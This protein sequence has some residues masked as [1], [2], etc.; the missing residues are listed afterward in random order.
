MHPCCA[1]QIL[2]L[3]HGR[4]PYDWL[5]KLQDKNAEKHAQRW[6]CYWNKD[7]GAILQK[8]ELDVK[9]RYDWHF[10]TTNWIRAC[11]QRPPS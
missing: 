1:G 4:S 3:E 8:A 7:I 10:G 2:L 5:A 9:A 11:P 6:G